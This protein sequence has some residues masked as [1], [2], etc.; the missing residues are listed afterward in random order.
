MLIEIQNNGL[1]LFATVENSEII[2]CK[3]SH[4]I[5]FLD[6]LLEEE[7]QLIMEKYKC[8]SI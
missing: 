5:N 2:E 8:L 7:K 3:S 1:T 4:G 6:I